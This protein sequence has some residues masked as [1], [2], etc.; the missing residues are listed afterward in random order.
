VFG[1]SG[2][3]RSSDFTFKKIKFRGGGINLEKKKG[4]NH[5]RP[6]ESHSKNSGVEHPRLVNHEFFT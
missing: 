3:K 4:R 6:W 2:Y 5:G 1:W